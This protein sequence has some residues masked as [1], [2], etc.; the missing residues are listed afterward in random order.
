MRHF[1]L[2]THRLPDPFEGISNCLAELSSLKHILVWAQV[3]LSALDQ[4]V[5]TGGGRCKMLISYFDD[6]DIVL[7]E[8]ACSRRF[9]Y[10]VGFDAYCRLYS[11]TAETALCFGR[12]LQCR[13]I[14]AT[15]LPEWG[16]AMFLE[17]SHL[18]PDPTDFDYHNA[19]LRFDCIDYDLY[20]PY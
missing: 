17:A 5:E 4:D 15:G 20:V 19:K 10:Q 1:E 8:T 11:L 7:Y 14:P 9:S 6:I 12:D 16:Y 18:E 3:S 13:D 2:L